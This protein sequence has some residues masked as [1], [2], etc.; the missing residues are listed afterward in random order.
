MV[1]GGGSRNPVL[2]R[3]LQELLDPAQIRLHEEFGLPSLGREAVYFALMGYEALHGRPNTVPSCTGA[4][5][6]VVM[7]KVVPGANYRRLIAARGQ[8]RRP[9]LRGGWSCAPRRR[10]GTTPLGISWPN[11]ASAAAWRWIG[12]SP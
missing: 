10:Y 3:L 7:G 9:P 6:A 1:G 12:R 11:S 8:R 5:H 4:S 2:M